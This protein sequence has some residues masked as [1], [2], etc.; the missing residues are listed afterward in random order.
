VG[1]S[2][3][4]VDGVRLAA[5]AEAVGTPAY[6]YSAA[7]IRAQYQA[8]DQALAPVPH[9]IHFAV[10]ANANLAV[11]G[12]LRQ[13]GAGVDIVSGGELVRAQRAGFR[14]EDV[15]FSGVGKTLEEMESALGAGVGIVNVESEEELELLARVAGAKGVSA[16]VAIRVNP[17][18]EVDVHPY[19]A[20]G[21]KAKKFGVPR[22]E[23]EALAWRA[24]RTPGLVLRGLA[25]HI[26]SGI[27]SVGPFVEAVL[28]VLEIVAALRERGVTS[29]TT[30]DLGGGLGIRYRPDDNPLDVTAY[31]EAILPHVAASRLNLV[32]EP[33]RFI[34]GNAGV[35]LTRVLYRK[36]S[37]GRMIAITDAGMT[38]LIRPSHYQAYHAIDV[39][40]GVGRAP[41]VYDV[42]GPIC[43]SG[44]FL[45]LEREL[46]ELRRGD[47]LAVRGAGAYGF[48]MSSTYNARP[49]PPEVMVDEGRFAVVRT[50]ES[51]EDLMRGET[52]TPLWRT[53]RGA[54]VP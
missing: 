22:D 4:K 21:D 40:G 52:M 12:L 50:R 34:V 30:L 26:G 13:L 16:A 45:A 38:D 29:L 33:G 28:R 53:S 7:K 51:V 43:E 1:E 17:D 31:A 46:P 48:V 2:V 39:D 54:A 15:V 47:L 36:R 5:I 11:L 49:R 18:V 37:G 42:V 8:L 24:S 35:L 44:D 20:T 32:V 23:A 14:G 10:K 6:V 9:R 19:T 27:G 41:V 25:M 3:L